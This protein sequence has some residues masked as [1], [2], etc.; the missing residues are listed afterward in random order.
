MSH[1]HIYGLLFR[2]LWPLAA[3]RTF[4]GETYLQPEEMAAAMASG[5]A[6]CL[7][8]SPAHLSRLKGFRGLT[9]IAAH[10]API[11][12][13]G[14]PVDRA[15]AVALRA[16]FAE[17]PFEIFGSTETGGVA[18]RQQDGTVDAETWTPFSGVAVEADSEGLLR[19]RSPF[20]SA[21]DGVFTL[22]D[23]VEVQR[24]G[25]FSAGP[26]GDRVVK[27]GDKRVSLPEMEAVLAEHE[28]VSQAALVV[29]DHGTGSRI[30]A[31]VVP[32]PAGRQLLSQQGRRAFTQSLTQSLQR[33]WA[34]I[35][36]PRVWRFVTRLPEDAQGK[37][38]V[39][40]LQAVFASPFDPAVASA[41]VVDE[42]VS[43]G[44]VQQ[45]LRV[46]ETLG[47]LDGHF[48]ELA[49][50]PGVAQLSWVMEAARAL[51][52]SEV[53]LERIEAL[54]FKSLLRPGEVIQLRA[55]LS[56]GRRLHFRID[57]ARTVFSSGCCV[58][59]AEPAGGA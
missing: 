7:I 14:G 42:A 59:A 16:A 11:F 32:T 19:V 25:R 2:V 43:A 38:T 21:P 31:A 5:P 8:T 27:V 24:D 50:V 55:E 35:L 20:V 1:Q 18:W 33:Y 6:G 48:A 53:A 51:A 34:G 49:V 29:L 41:E 26:R 47:C 46:P 3:G 36:L 45:T 4:R 54:K 12:S 17:S 39:A 58:L 37:I 23:R 57:N 10:C 9:R 15:T 22:A 52:G 56:A 44:V 30:G 28:L 40:A 13:S